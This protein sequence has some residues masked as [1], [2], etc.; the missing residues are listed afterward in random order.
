MPEATADA[1]PCPKPAPP[2]PR[3]PAR[4]LSAARRLARCFLVAMVPFF[5]RR[6]LGLLAGLQFPMPDFLHGEG[7][8][9]G[10]GCQ[11]RGV[12]RPHGQ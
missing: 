4:P 3:A 10:R 7:Q 1:V 2:L 5:V 6:V 9:A 11:G 8:R 12:R